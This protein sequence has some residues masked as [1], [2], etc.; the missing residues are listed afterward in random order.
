MSKNEKLFLYEI[1]NSYIQRLN[2]VEP[3]ETVKFFV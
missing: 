3:K 1:D 2:E